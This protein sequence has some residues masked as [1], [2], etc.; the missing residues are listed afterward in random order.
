MPKRLPGRRVKHRMKRNWMKMYDQEGA[1]RRVE[2]VINDPEEFRI[3]RRVRR[4]GRSV[5]AWVPLRTGV[6]YLS[7]YQEI[8]GQCNGRYLEALAK[9]LKALPCGLAER[10]AV[11]VRGSR[12]VTIGAFWRRRCPIRISGNARTRR[13][14]DRLE[15]RRTSPPPMACTSTCGAK[16]RYCA[17]GAAAQVGC[18]TDVS[19]SGD[20]DAA[21]EVD[22]LHAVRGSDNRAN[23]S[24]TGNSEDPAGERDQSE[25]P[26]SLKLRRGVPPSFAKASEGILRSS[27]LWDG[28]PSEA[29]P[30][31]SEEERRMGRGESDRP[32]NPLILRAIGVAPQTRCPQC[33]PLAWRAA[34]GLR[35]RVEL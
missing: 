23:R 13:R 29:L 25:C 19:L 20:G 4:Q 21:E 28:M 17:L 8:C 32:R 9:S 24:A 15:S 30:S 27:S 11:S 6:A 7:R 33:C 3:R 1:V 10:I 2:T 22:V 18:D 26:P 12:L 14:G 5:M 35:R 16:P 31:G 34:Q